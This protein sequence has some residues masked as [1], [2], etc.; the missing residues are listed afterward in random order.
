MRCDLAREPAVGARDRMADQ[1]HAADDAERAAATTLEGPEQVGLLKP[2]DGADT[3]VGGD[4]LKLEDASGTRAEPLRVR[5]ET[6]AEG[7]AAAGA[8]AGAPAALDV[9]SSFRRGAVGLE[10]AVA[11]TGR[12]RL[13]GRCAAWRAGGYE[14]FMN[15]DLAHRVRPN[16]QRV[17][18][19][20]ASEV[21]VPGAFNC[22]SDAV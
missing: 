12:E 14:G 22:D 7:K 11:G 3:T 8:D 20:R 10:P 13:Y 16:Q 21:V 1:G 15:G 2:I 18:R 17:R 5:P 6:A 4:D 9:A 19:A